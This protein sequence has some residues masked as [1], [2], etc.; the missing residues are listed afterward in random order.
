MLRTDEI[1]IRDPF[2]VP[3]APTGNYWM[4]GTTS[5]FQG[6]AVGFDTWH[7]TDLQN[8]E[9]SVPAFRPPPD[10]WSDTQFW[11]PEVHAW[12]DA[13]YMFATFKAEGRYRG[14]QILKAAN[15]EGPYVPISD[16]PVTPPDWEC[17]DGTLYVAPDGTPWIVFCHEWAQI[18]N[19]SICAM[20]LSADLTAAAGRPAYLF[21]AS[22]A[23]WS[24]PLQHEGYRFPC[25]V[26]DGPFLYRAT[27]GHLLMLWSSFGTG[28]YITG[29][30]CSASG[31]I[32]GPWTQDPTPLY[33]GDAGHAMIFRTFEGQL[34]LSLHHPNREGDERAMFLPIQEHDSQLSLV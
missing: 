25:R 23:A 21:S 14:T 28:G 22:E 29:I 7:S 12:H 30:A 27:N 24:K 10:F 4:F 34:T 31:E 9:D 32:T 1:R 5:M 6:K 33:T 26:T 20:P 19:G 18:H 15:L 2:I 16:G 11:A 17:L 13:W 3:H 8:W